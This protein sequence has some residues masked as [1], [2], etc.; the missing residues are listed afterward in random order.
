M[1]KSFLMLVGIL[2]VT[3]TSCHQNPENGGKEIRGS[4]QRSDTAMN[5]GN[6][7]PASSSPGATYNQD[8]SSSNMGENNSSSQQGK[9]TNIPNNGGG[10]HSNNERDS[11]LSR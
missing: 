4:E 2:A 9:A 7:S 6:G 5:M 11:S 8:P 3:I 1:K 10:S